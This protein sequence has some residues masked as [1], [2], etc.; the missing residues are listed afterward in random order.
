MKV[1]KLSYQERR[2]LG[3]GLLFISPWLVGF[4]SF[5]VYPLLASLYYSFTRYDVLRPAKFIGL[6]NYQEIFFGDDIFREVLGNTLYFVLVGVPA[7]FLT[8]FLLANLLNTNIW[9][10]SI[11]R[12]I[13]FLPAIT[14]AVASVMVWLWIYNTQYGLING[15][16][17]ANGMPVIP[18]LSSPPLAKP[19]LIIVQC[20]AQGTAIVI[21]LAALQWLLTKCGPSNATELY[22]VYLYRNAFVFFKMGYASALAWLLFLIIVVFSIIIFRSSARWVYYRGE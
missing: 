7:S 5:T 16:L 2:N 17:A 15:F 11:L 6:A 20:W 10:R 22:S 19:S 4:V 9:G 8:A 3:K 1:R 12:T 21:F 14:P 13:F 18:W